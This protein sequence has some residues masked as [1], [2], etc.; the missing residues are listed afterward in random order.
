ME[1]W[2]RDLLV[3]YSYWAIVLLVAIEGDVTLL[4]TGMLAHE[5]LLGF[6]FTTA[7]AAAMVGAVGGDV[8]SFLFGRRIRK[9]ITESK[10]YKKFYPRFE[11]LEQR[12]GFVSILLVKWIYGMRFAS[13]VFWG[14]SRM[15]VWRFA[16]LTLF[17][18]GV[19][20]G[21][22]TGLGW[23]CGTAVSVFLS[24]LQSVA[25]AVMLTVVGLFAVRAIHHRWIS[26]RLQQGAEQ[27]GFTQD[28]KPE[29][30][31]VMVFENAR[32]P[33]TGPSDTVR[34]DVSSSAQADG[35]VGSVQV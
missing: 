5:H 29:T 1:G 19:W 35:D 26:P 22:L 10:I 15:G 20:V 2:I 6:G 8:V 25:A 4:V 9:N 16:T 11:Y 12:F 21:T 31:P 33:S 30:A 32:E 14:V 13:S 3:I 7:L 27:A 23:L 24:R 28:L 17:S 18:C 34:A